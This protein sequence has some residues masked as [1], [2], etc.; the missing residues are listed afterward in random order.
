MSTIKIDWREGYRNSR[1][2]SE[3]RKKSKEENGM[4]QGKTIREFLVICL[5]AF[6]KQVQIA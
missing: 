3:R 2:R 1:R 6:Y 4:T 5:G